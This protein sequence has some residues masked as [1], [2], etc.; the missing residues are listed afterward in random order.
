[1]R[2]VIWWYTVLGRSILKPRYG[3]VGERLRRGKLW[4]K[5]LFVRVA[6]RA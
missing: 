3:S 6:S 2:T 4:I 1:M 5:V